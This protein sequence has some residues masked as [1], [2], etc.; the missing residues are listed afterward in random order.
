MRKL[1]ILHIILLF[2]VFAW[3]QQGTTVA[4]GIPYECGFEEGTDLSPWMLNN[5]N[6]PTPP[7]DQW[8]VGSAVH[9]EGKRALYV[10]KDS[11]NPNYGSHQN[12]VVSY[13]RFRFPTSSKTE[14]YDLSFDWKGRGDSTFS[15]LFVMVCPE[16]C[17][18]DPANYPEYNLNSIVSNVQG[19]LS[20]STVGQCVYLGDMQYVCGSEEWQNV[21]W[22][23][24][25]TSS[26]SSYTWAIVFIWENSNTD[27]LVDRTGLAID[28]FQINSAAL[29][30]PTDLNGIPQCEDSTLLVTWKSTLSLFDIEYRQYGDRT[31]RRANG[32]I[33]GM[34]GFTKNGENCSFVLT[35][36]LEGTYE[37]RIRGGDATDPNLKTG[38]VYQTGILVYCPENHCIN[39]IDLHSPNVICTTGHHPGAQAGATPYDV[40]EIVDFG[41]DAEMS[42]HTL[43]VD[44]EEMDP[45]TDSLLPTVPPGALASVRL[46][47]WH[48]LGEAESITYDIT[49]DAST[50]GILLVQYA[51]VFQN[52]QGHPVED[53]PAFKLEVLTTDGQLIDEF[54]GQRNFT[55]S[56]GVKDDAYGWHITKDNGVAWKE[57]STVGLNLQPYDGQ[58]IKVRFTTLDCGYS[59][60]Y[61]YAYFTVDCANANIETNNCGYEASI[62]CRAPDGFSYK[63]Y[64]EAGNVVS[65][66]QELI[67][68]PGREVY[69]CHVSFKD[70]STCYFEVSTLSAPRFPVA[71][72]TVEP[73]QKEC[74]NL[75]K[76]HNTSHVMNKFEG[77]ENHT[78]EPCNDWHWEFRRLPNDE[79]QMT[80]A[81]HPII[82]CP[83]EGGLIEV[84][85]ISYIGE[86]NACSDTLIDTIVVTSIIPEATTF[87]VETCPETPVAFGGKR[88][89]TD[90]VYV[91]HFPN[92]AECDSVSTL[93][94]TVYPKVPD[95]YRHDSI[96]SDGVVTINGVRYNQPVE[97][98]L[99][100]LKTAHGCDSVVYFTLTVNQRIDATIHQWPFFCAD[101]EQ[102][103]VTFD[104]AAGV[105]DSLEILF[106]TPALRDTVIYDSNISSVAIPY[107]DTITPGYYKATLRFHQYC[108]GIYTED[109]TVE[110][111]YRSSIVEQ[112]WNDVLTVLSPKYNGG[113]EF[114]DFQWYK[115]GQLL[116]G[117][118][119]SYLYQPLDMNST[120]YVEL[121]RTDG[122]V[123]TT[124]PIQPEYHEQQSQYPSIVP[125]GQHMPMYMEQP[126]TI[127]Y[128]TIS[129]QLYRSFGLPQ[130]YTSLP[131][132]EQTGAYILKAV[133]AQG[134]TQAQVMIVQ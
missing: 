31:W 34:P 30:K 41:P 66:S 44:P 82:T 79:P 109:R 64:N 14:R 43:H 65:E 40:I 97:N 52:P 29:P 103:Y 107:P 89:D 132:P 87:Y 84:K 11:L 102:L 59:G 119:H 91:G 27:T 19:R 106:D 116:E 110:I 57:W 9:S 95:T 49:V 133:N 33:E 126:V 25:I 23:E 21:S 37:L 18:T 73:V 54:C 42:R 120:Y 99:I 92:F 45:R 129:G 63:W 69:T 15:R 47:N 24:K 101:D 83:E 5:P 81:E 62:T 123:M 127:W 131:I 56:D 77:Y 86:F 90:T 134:E 53:E 6:P 74:K 67:V 3:S 8:M 28:N 76:F 71:E 98:K 93:Y 96:C 10:T 68:G 2:S 35:R 114:T 115:D 80:D 104:I 51:V 46:G 111:R 78:S 117:E 50:Q 128:Y 22:E 100:R 20:N 32:L 75:L 94:L 38:F 112:K 108:C 4:S 113:F 17:L 55:Y 12:V 16:M 58:T 88:F 125:A 85:L 60:H 124:C 13:L 130:G 61:S 105:F 7:T 72:Y 36:I 1:L 26:L 122:L 121:K 48:T 118:T 39:Y 70:D